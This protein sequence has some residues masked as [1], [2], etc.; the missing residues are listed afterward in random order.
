MKIKI[1][2]VCDKDDLVAYLKGGVMENN[3][4][5]KCGYS[6]WKTKVKGKEYQC[7]KCGYIKKIGGEENGR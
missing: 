6:R 4:C 7:R 3:I 1:V 2:A 5:P